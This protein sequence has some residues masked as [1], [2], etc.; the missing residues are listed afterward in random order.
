MEG[1]T[2][3]KVARKLVEEQPRTFAELGALLQKRWRGRDPA[4]LAQMARALLPLVQVPPRGIW[5]ASG[6]ALH[7]TAESWLGRSLTEEPSL[8]AMVMRYLGA[9]GPAS[10]QDA[11]CWCGLTRLRD[12]LERLRPQL[13]TFRD[14]DGIELFDLPDAPRPDPGTPAPVRFLPE[15]DNVLLSHADRRRIASDLHRQRFVSPNGI[16]PGSVLVDGFVRGMWRMRPDRKETVLV[17]DLFEP[18]TKRERA[19]VGAEA[20]AL[21]EAMSPAAASPAAPRR[22]VRFEPPA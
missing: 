6:G 19:A 5:G 14:E 3:A 2:L 18:P 22:I 7:T 4:A 16:V 1:A 8:D 12:V 11:Q 15:Y 10:V 17:V 21:L 13:V 20:E 9:F